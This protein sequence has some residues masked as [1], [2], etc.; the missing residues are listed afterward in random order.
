LCRYLPGSR[1]QASTGKAIW[2]QQNG[3]CTKIATTT[4]Q[5]P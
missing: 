2:R 3:T 1:G 4:K 5:L